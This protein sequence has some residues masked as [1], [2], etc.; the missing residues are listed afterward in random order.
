MNKYLKNVL[1]GFLAW[2]IPFIAAFLFY[3]RDGKLTIDIFLFKSIMI[4]VGS[5]TAAFLLVSYFKKIN[6]EYLKEGILVGVIWF[7]VNILLDVLVLIPMS[8]MSISNYFTQIG[9]KY[10]AIPA[11]SIAVGAS[12]ANKK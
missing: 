4:V 12:L 6:A 7:A 8:G 3:T 11:M 10:L 9:L 5:T 1:Y 2:L